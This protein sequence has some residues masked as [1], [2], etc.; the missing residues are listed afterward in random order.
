MVKYITSPIAFLFIALSWKCA[1]HPLPALDSA[2]TPYHVGVYTNGVH[3][4]FLFPTKS[5]QSWFQYVSPRNYDTNRVKYLLFGWGDYQF[6]Q[7]TPTWDDFNLLT[8]LEALFYS[9]RSVV[10]VTGIEGEFKGANYIKIA[11]NKE[12]CMNLS[13]YV[14]KSFKNSNSALLD[15]LSSGYTEVDFFYD[16]SLHYSALNTCNNWVASGFEELGFSL[17]F[18]SGLSG[19]VFRALEKSERTIKAK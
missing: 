11:L 15:P 2:T 5:C 14:L 10:H 7:E 13:T 19:P 4:S 1:S 6:Y 8:G 17:P 16:S 12:E 9:S 3:L 18:W